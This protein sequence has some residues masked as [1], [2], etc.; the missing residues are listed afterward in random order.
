M[1]QA[2]TIITLTA[3]ILLAACG[4][5]KETLS[6]TQTSSSVGLKP[7]LPERHF[8]VRTHDGLPSASELFQELDSNYRNG[9]Q[10]RF[11]IARDENGN[12]VCRR[13]HIESVNIAEENQKYVQV[14]D[15]SQGTFIELALFGDQALFIPRGSPQVYSVDQKVVQDVIEDCNNYEDQLQATINYG[16]NWEP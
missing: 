7:G 9:G 5:N 10:G 6:S 12:E 15:V 4:E 8:E 3:A 1:K 11:T 16:T 2:F 14:T 13:E